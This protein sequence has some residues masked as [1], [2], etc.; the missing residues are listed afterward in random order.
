[1]FTQTLMLGGGKKIKS[2]FRGESRVDSPTIILLLTLL[3]LLRA[4]VVQWA[5]NKVAPR[6]ISNLGNPR[7]Q[8]QPLTFEEALIFTLLVTFLF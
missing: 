2:I 5:Y 3:F 8:F 6:L 1:M 4:L 7:Q